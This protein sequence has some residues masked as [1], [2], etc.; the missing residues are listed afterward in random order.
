MTNKRVKF[1]CLYNEVND[2]YENDVVLKFKFKS[3]LT[4]EKNIKTPLPKKNQM[5]KL[6]KCYILGLSEPLLD[7]QQIQNKFFGNPL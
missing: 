7:M 2:S 4:Q 1:S 6:R 5:I 3:E